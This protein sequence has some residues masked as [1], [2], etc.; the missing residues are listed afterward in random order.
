MVWWL[1]EVIASWR[2][3][4]LFLESTRPGNEA[5]LGP[6]FF[7]SLSQNTG[8]IEKRKEAT[9][10]SPFSW[11]VLSFFLTVFYLI[12]LCDK[13]QKKE[14]L[15]RRLPYSAKFSRGLIFAVFVG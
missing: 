15:R 1:F 14:R 2:S 12:D 11:T 13:E 5:S 4:V 6:S 10:V 3:A 9:E 7:C 8:R